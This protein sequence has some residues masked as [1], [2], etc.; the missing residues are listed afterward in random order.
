M[1]W[2]GVCLTGVLIVALSGCN[3]EANQRVQTSGQSGMAAQKVAEGNQNEPQGGRPVLVVT[4]RSRDDLVSIYSGGRYTV[5]NVDGELLAEL[6][7]EDEFRQLLPDLFA[8]IDGALADDTWA[9]YDVNRNELLPAEP[10]RID[11][12]RPTTESPKP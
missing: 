12:V 1:K 7:T 10:G 5:E 9:G 3:P 6:V 2:M 4:I 8:R 11:V